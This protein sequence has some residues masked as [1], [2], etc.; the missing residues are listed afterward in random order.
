MAIKNSGKMLSFIFGVF[1]L[2]GGFINSTAFASGEIQ[3][4]SERE[5][6][7]IIYNSS[8]N[9]VLID[10]SEPNR[11]AS[12]YDITTIISK[13]LGFKCHCGLYCFE[14]HICMA[15]TP[16]TIIFRNLRTNNQLTKDLIDYFKEVIQSDTQSDINIYYSLSV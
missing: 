9:R 7:S 15:K 13:I 12:L 6:D 1:V 10:F 14:G 11:Y 2:L 4:I 16:T 3:R 8:N 5:I